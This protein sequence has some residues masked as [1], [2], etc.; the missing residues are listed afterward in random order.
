MS[1]STSLRLVDAP[2]RAPICAVPTMATSRRH[3][4]CS[5]VGL[6]GGPSGSPLGRHHSMFSKEVSQSA[7]SFHLASTR[8]PM[9]TWSWGISWMGPNTTT[10]APSG[11]NSADRR[12]RWRVPRRTRRSP[13]R[14]DVPCRAR[15]RRSSVGQAVDRAHAPGAGRRPCRCVGQRSP[16]SLP[17]GHAPQEAGL[18]YAR[19]CSRSRR[20][21]GVRRTAPARTAQVRTAGWRLGPQPSGRVET[22]RNGLSRSVAHA[23][24]PALEA[25]DVGDRALALVGPADLDPHAG[26]HGVRAGGVHGVQHRGVGTVEPDQRPGERRGR[27]AGRRARRRPSPRGDRPLGADL[28]QLGEGAR[29]SGSY[30]TGGHITRPSAL[31]TPSTPSRSPVKKAPMT[32]PVVRVNG[33][34]TT[35][36]AWS[37]S[38]VAG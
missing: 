5:L 31:R 17:L 7:A 14:S 38:L 6:V 3:H 20:R 19:R 25:G 32:G 35:S 4:T 18:G 26:A 15:P 10:S 36:G 22:L 23:A 33:Y 34:S 16:R 12:R 24:P 11:T 21:A 9:W 30:S 1:I 28:D 29:W 2:A 8:M 13:R 37:R 27:A